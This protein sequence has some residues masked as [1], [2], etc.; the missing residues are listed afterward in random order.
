MK[1]AIKFLSILTIVT[2]ALLLNSC[3]KGKDGEPGKDGSVNVTST[4]FSVSSWSSDSKKYYTLLSVPELTSDNINSASVQVYFSSVAN[5]W[6]AMPYT[7]IASTNYFMG[8]TSTI[9]SIQVN[10][11]YN[12]LGIGDDPNEFYGISAS[13]F[14]V[15]I[16]PTAILKQYPNINLN[17]FNEVKE[18]FQLKD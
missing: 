15:V 18:T 8:Y 1:R 11:Y 6:I 10:W 2:I 9:N 16:I 17:N 7:Q 4:V 14:K 3:K 5:T 12:G 13:K